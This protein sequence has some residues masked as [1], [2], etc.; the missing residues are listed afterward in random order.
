M[1]Q[2]LI[3]TFAFIRKEII[4]I[5]RQPR[6]VLSFILGP[7]LILLLFGIGYR[8][9]PRILRTVFVVEE[10]SPMVP[11]VED[12]ADRLGEQIDSRGIVHDPAEAD[13]MLRA[14][15]ADLI[16]VVPPDPQTQI[17][18]NEQ[19]TLSLYHREIDPYEVTYLTILGNNYAEA[20]NRDVLMSAIDRSKADARDL[21]EKVSEARQAASA[22][23]LALEANDGQ[24]VRE[25]TGLL[26]QNLELLTLSAGTG[27]ALLAG[28]ESSVET[29]TVQARLERLH[30]SSGTLGS[31]TTPIA[32]QAQVAAGIEDDLTEI[33]GLLT[34]YLNLDSRIVVSPFRADTSSIAATGIQATD[35]FVPAVIALLMQHFAVTLAGLSIVRER[36]YGQIELFR[37]SPVT[38]FQTLIGKYLGYLLFTIILGAILTWLAVSV[39]G[40]P[41]LGSWQ[42]YALVMIALLCASLSLGFFF[43]ISAKTDSQAIQA[44][45]LV[46][47]ASIFFSGFFLALYRLWE[48]VQALSWSLPVTYGIDL[49]QSVMLRGENPNP[50]LLGGLFLFAVIFLGVDWWRLSQVMR[51]R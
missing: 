32:D 40:V 47:L 3:R 34:D 36:Q 27:M 7:F 23:R 24:E 26:E 41:M 2:S 48:P 42:A 33:D 20:I 13:R 37:A 18:H 44:A 30:E 35:Y 1:V 19:A 16:V 31:G 15:E 49:L 14:G 29:D 17:R 11:F 12:Y 28:V 8:D 6:L 50:L 4:G 22:A 51:Q 10:D 38:P 45:M 9:D 43:S 21:R 46:L 39:L 5:L 25:T